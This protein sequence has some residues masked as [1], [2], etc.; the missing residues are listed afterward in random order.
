MVLRFGSLLQRGK[1]LAP[2]LRGRMVGAEQPLA[3]GHGSLKQRDRFS[4]ATR[5]LVSDGEVVSRAS[6]PDMR[7]S[8]TRGRP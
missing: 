6:Y 5:S 1:V 2:G 8:V 7:H 4:G 3:V